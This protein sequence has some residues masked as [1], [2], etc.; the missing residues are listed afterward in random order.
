MWRFQFKEVIKLLLRE[1]ADISFRR[2]FSNT[3]HFNLKE[4]TMVEAKLS[5]QNVLNEKFLC[6]HFISKVLFVFGFIFNISLNIIFGW[7]LI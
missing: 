4:N 7:L 6:G 5:S 3:Q 2:V 1:L